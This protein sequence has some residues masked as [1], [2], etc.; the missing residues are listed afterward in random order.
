[1][2]SEVGSKERDDWQ[3]FAVVDLAIW[4]WEILIIGQAVKKEKIV[5]QK[6]DH[7]SPLLMAQAFHY[8]DLSLLQFG[9][10]FIE[11]L[12]FDSKLF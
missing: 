11:N 5:T 6:I 1:M 7:A 10:D 8:F 2:E 12:L 9:Y 4:I 3:T